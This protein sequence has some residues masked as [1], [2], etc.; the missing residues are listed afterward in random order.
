MANLTTVN[1][2]STMD[3]SSAE[4]PTTEPPSPREKLF[5]D[6]FNV[7]KAS[8]K[9]NWD[10]AKVLEHP[11]GPR[12]V[13]LV[14]AT[15]EQRKFYPE[16]WRVQFV[17]QARTLHSFTGYRDIRS[18]LFEW[19]K[20]RQFVPPDADM[21]IY[22][23][24]QIRRHLKRLAQTPQE[25]TILSSSALAVVK[26]T[27]MTILTV[28]NPETMDRDD[29]LSLRP[30]RGGYEIGVHTPLL[31]HVVARGSVWDRWAFDMAVSI[32]MPHLVI[33][34]LPHEIA[35]KHAS[36]DAGTVR[37][38]L[39]FYFFTA[40]KSAPQFQRVCCE[41]IKIQRNADYQQIA[42]WLAASQLAEKMAGKWKVKDTAK[43]KEAELHTAVQ[44]WIGAAEH[45][46]RKRVKAGGRKFDREQ[47][48][49]MVAKN[50]AVQLRRYSQASAEHKMVSEWMIAA[51]H[52]AARFCAEHQLPCIY[53]VQESG[54]ARENEEGSEGG[55]NFTRPQSSLEMAPHRDLGIEGYAQITSPLR[56]YSDLLVQ[57]QIAAFLQKG[58]PVY[59]P[60]EL[61]ACATAIEET[62]RRI[63]KIEGKAEFYYK[64]VYLKQHRGE[65]FDAEISYGPPPARN[66]VLMLTD[67]GLRLF[68]PLAS[69][70]GLNARQ[71]P[72]A[73]SPF[74]VR[75]LCHNMD[76]D[77]G[78]STFQIKRAFERYDRR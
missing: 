21:F 7:F 40:G 51:N 78:T 56:R 62:A 31:E 13:R 75:A 45:L 64:C 25:A 61:L 53:R 2:N 44:V 19:L 10:R 63:H 3:Q 76:P 47:I 6:L 49:V 16:A 41:E 54:G 18:L 72:P 70:K 60:Q 12:L 39:S 43:I 74:A 52:A 14:R 9:D 42:Q 55:N 35:T 32:Y 33:P 30:V 24:G 38:V 59:A 67:L 29:A 5:E 66:V 4:M 17:R 65:T 27:E 15:F 28:D 1:F 50:G 69:I 23:D 48:D 34:M 68:L 37:P 36:L 57:R 22:S 77:R 73:D 58:A 71:I 26:Q 8:L 46:E 20:T 11:L